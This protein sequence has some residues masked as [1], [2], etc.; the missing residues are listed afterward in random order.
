M[1]ETKRA[2]WRLEAGLGPVNAGGVGARVTAV[3]IFAVAENHASVQEGGAEEPE[4]RR[5]CSWLWKEH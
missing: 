2:A 5:Y 4:G 1:C 3:S